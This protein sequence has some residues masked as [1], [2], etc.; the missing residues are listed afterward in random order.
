MSLV[1]FKETDI[2]QEK[3]FKNLVL[4]IFKNTKSLNIFLERNPKY[5]YQ[6]FGRNQTLEEAKEL[7]FKILKLLIDN[8]VQFHKF[9]SDDDTE[10]KILELITNTKG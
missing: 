3:E 10:D 9:M 6:S 8:D 5:Q 7:D 1:Y 2:L 4:S